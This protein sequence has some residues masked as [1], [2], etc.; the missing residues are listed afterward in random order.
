MKKQIKLVAIG[1]MLASIVV[2]AFAQGPGADTYKSKCAMC[3]GGDGMGAT[4]AGKAMKTPPF[5]SP[6]ILK[7]SDTDLIAVTKSGKGKMPAYSGKLTDLQIKD[8]IAYI[9]TL[10]K[11]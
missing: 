5:N 6:D 3:H 1:I 8:V 4:P 9:H 7:M 10:Q 11:K 2:P